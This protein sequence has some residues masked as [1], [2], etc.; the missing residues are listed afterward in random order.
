MTTFKIS[1]IDNII[2]LLLCTILLILLCNLVYL[3]I[4]YQKTNEIGLFL[5]N[6]FTITFPSF[7]KN[8]S[9]IKF[10]VLPK[11]IFILSTILIILSIIALIPLT[12]ESARNKMI[13]IWTRISIQKSI[14][15]NASETKITD[16]RIN[17]FE[18]LLS[19]KILLQNFNSYIT[20]YMNIG[21]KEENVWRSL[22]DKSF[23]NKTTYKKNSPGYPITLEYYIN[24][25][26][27][28]IPDKK[29][30]V[31][32]VLDVVA[33]DIK[34]SNKIP[35]IEITLKKK[36]EIDSI[37]K[38]IASKLMQNLKQKI[39]HF[40]Q[41]III[42]Y[43]IK[44]DRSYVIFEKNT[45]STE[46]NIKTQKSEEN[47][48]VANSFTNEYLDA[49]LKNALYFKTYT[50]KSNYIELTSFYCTSKEHEK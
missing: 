43:K 9:T 29:K 35:V 18:S 28:S 38:I 21:H 5:K 19:I 49:L 24:S 36:S 39:N 33:K 45:D 16:E 11:K 22:D 17:L 30:E 26:N 1:I 6:L 31:V 32:A 41:P 12:I 37:N 40:D 25:K 23:I 44:R 13:E 10:L 46:Y 2:I 3:S 14:H 50:N 42:N 7:L 34:K 48:I 20:I 47:K 8:P 27:E 15:N 4:H